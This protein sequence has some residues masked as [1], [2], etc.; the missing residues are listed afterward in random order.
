MRLRAIDLANSSAE[1]K[2]GAEYGAELRGNVT[3]ALRRR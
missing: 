1:M 3:D 2:L